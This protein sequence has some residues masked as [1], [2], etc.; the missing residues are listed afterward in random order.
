MEPFFPAIWNVFHDGC[1]EQIE[2]SAPGMVSVHVGIEYL[3]EMFSDPGEYFLVTFPNCTKFSFQHYER[4]ELVVDLA[5]IT[6]DFPGIL[7]AQMDG[8]VCKVFTDAGLLKMSSDDGSIRLDSGRE[9][10]LDELLQAATKYW[11]DWEAKSRD[12]K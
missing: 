7:S 1:I 3:R 8:D 4:D 6:E 12:K 11:D 9:I 5:S 10:S 2:G